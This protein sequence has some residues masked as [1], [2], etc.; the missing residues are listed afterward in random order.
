MNRFLKI[1]VRSSQHASLFRRASRFPA[2]QERVLA[3]AMFSSFTNGPPHPSQSHTNI[4]NNQQHAQSQAPPSLELPANVERDL[5]EQ[6]Q[7]QQQQQ[8][9]DSSSSQNT[10]FQSQLPFTNITFSSVCFSFICLLNF[11]QFSK[12]II[13]QF[14]FFLFFRMNQCFE[15]QQ[16]KLFSRNHLTFQLCW[17]RLPLGMRRPSNTC[18]P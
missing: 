3:A 14:S 5:R 13:F 12:S 9:P 2:N 6:K 15:R 17:L 16:L 10:P 7:Q 18:K 4:N 1:G 8:Q 11:F